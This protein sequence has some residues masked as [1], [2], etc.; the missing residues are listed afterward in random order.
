M[1]DI[2]LA[3][4]LQI[5]INCM[6][7]VFMVLVI[8]MGLVSLFKYLPQTE[9][10]TKSHKVKKDK[11][12]SFDEMDDDMKVAALVATINYKEQTNKEVKLKS[13]RRI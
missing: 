1:E 5:T 10:R 2:N 3:E 4:A 7:I 11:Y 12:V 8:L 6:L 9:I 13:I